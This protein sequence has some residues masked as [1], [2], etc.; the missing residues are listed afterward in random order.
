MNLKCNL[1]VMM[2]SGRFLKKVLTALVMVLDSHS[3]ES[4]RVSRSDFRLSSPMVR[5]LVTLEATPTTR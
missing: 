4:S 3:K 1:Y 2:G 5:S